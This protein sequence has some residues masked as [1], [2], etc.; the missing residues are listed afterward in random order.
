[1]HVASSHCCHEQNERHQQQQQH[2]H[3][4][5]S[6][7]QRN[8]VCFV[9]VETTT[10]RLKHYLVCSMPSVVCRLR[11]VS[12][13]E[14]QTEP[15]HID[16]VCARNGVCLCILRY[17]TH[18]NSE[19]EPTKPKRSRAH[20]QQNRRATSEFAHIVGEQRRRAFARDASKPRILAH[21]RRLLHQRQ[22]ISHTEK[23]THTRTYTTSSTIIIE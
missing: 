10:E 6:T 20:R 4:I 23:G 5:R 21:V 15:D 11:C 8:T 9:G 19:M 16:V 18:W 14:V 12:K 13:T 22:R 3:R 1:M 2:R 7:G 17:S